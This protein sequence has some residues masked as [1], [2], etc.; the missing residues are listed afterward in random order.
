[1][2]NSLRNILKGRIINI[3]ADISEHAED[4][5]KFCTSVKENMDA[6]SVL[7]SETVDKSIE[8]ISAN[9]V[10]CEQNITD[11]LKKEYK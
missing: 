5:M 2:D 9:L 6:Q 4:L 10:N 3:Q 1:M 8:T 11:E 7:F